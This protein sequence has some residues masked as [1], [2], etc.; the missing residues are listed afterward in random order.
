MRIV[1]SAFAQ[2]SIVFALLALPV[3]IAQDAATSQPASAAG[4]TE[5]KP[6]T[7]KVIEV[8]GDVRAAALDSNEWKPIKLGD[9]LPEQTKVLTGV[10]SS[11]K[12]QIGS[13]EPY[14]CLLIDSVG[15]TVISEA[16]I[17]GDNKKVRVGVAYGRVKAGVAEGGLK[18]DFTVDSPVATLSKRGTWGFSLAYER[19]TEAFEIG[20]DERGLVNAL[21]KMRDESRN[22]RPGERVTEAMRSWLD[23]SQFRNTPIA[24]VFGQSDVTVAFNRIDNEGV[25][26]LAAGSGRE[27]LVNLTNPG[28]R[29]DFASLL[30]RALQSSTLQGLPGGNRVFR[31]E[32]FFGT[33]RG[34]DLV[35]VLIDSSN[36]LSQRGDA[37]AG[38][39]FFRRDAA[40]TWLKQGRK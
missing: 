25:G 23:E 27:L 33:G 28:T 14:T 15:K 8:Q 26:V 2:V 3:A 11:V 21:N 6:I 24:D 39:Y 1:K 29:G 7:A 40:E 4:T 31:R 16:A 30:E 34:D 18:S 17:T 9:E 32:G 36:P 22:V 13:E 35:E 20:L 5:R 10:R 12:L 37:R 19:D 38:R